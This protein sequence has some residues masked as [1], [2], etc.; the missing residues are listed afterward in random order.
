MLSMNPFCGA[1]SGTEK[2]KR[3][4]IWSKG[5]SKVENSNHSKGNKK[6][7]GTLYRKAKKYIT[8]T[9]QNITYLYMFL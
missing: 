7:L 8:N 6:R 3:E 9:T 5:E 2:S 4:H 1:Q